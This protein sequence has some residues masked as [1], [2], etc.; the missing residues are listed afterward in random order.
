MPSGHTSGTMSP[1]LWGRCHHDISVFEATRICQ[2]TLPPGYVTPRVTLPLVL[3]PAC[4]QGQLGFPE[5]GGSGIPWWLS[6]T[7]GP[8][9]TS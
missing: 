7:S 9:V 5:R 3:S 2:G 6:P 1:H 8:L 4:P